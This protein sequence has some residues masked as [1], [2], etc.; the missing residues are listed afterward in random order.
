MGDSPQRLDPTEPCACS[1]SLFSS[2]DSFRRQAWLPSSSADENGGQ[3]G[4]CLASVAGAVADQ[5]EDRKRDWLAGAAMGETG[6]EQME[7]CLDMP[8]G[9][10]AGKGEIRCHLVNKRNKDLEGQWKS[11]N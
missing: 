2:P 8:E 11:S 3:E 9:R 10:T 4:G 5:D 1:V 6:S 7:T